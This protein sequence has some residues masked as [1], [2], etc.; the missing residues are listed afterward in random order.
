MS[1]TSIIIPTHNR[2]DLLT[3]AV[4][5]AFAAGTKIE[6]IV[7]DDASTDT[8]ADVCASLQGIKY[9]RLEH[10]EGVAGA[11]NRGLLA[12]SGEYVTFL[13]DDDV[14][15]PNSI[16]DQVKL[17]EADKQAGLIF[18]QAILGDQSGAPTNEVYP[19]E[20]AQGDVFWRLMSHN[21]IPCGSVVFRRS[22]VDR[23][24]LLD[25]SIP[26]VDDWDLWV[27][28]AEVYK[29]IAIEK[30]VMIWR[31]STSISGQGTSQA[32]Y[33][34]SR[35][36]RQFRRSWLKLSRAAKA[37]PEMK[38]DTWRQFSIPMAAHVLYDSPPALRSG[39]LKRAAKNILAL[40]HLCPFIVVQFARKRSRLR[41]LETSVKEV[42]GTSTSYS[43]SSGTDHRTTLVN[44]DSA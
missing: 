23:V 1:L 27:R 35:A 8:T 21:F 9:V 18:G 15:L 6:V 14:R 41:L 39:D 30:P 12:S 2:P 3:R 32:A 26:G 44:S 22:C 10:N 24:G 16:D 19:F 43:G 11:R 38:R 42:H 33:M 7:V 37:S 31:R 36:A 17:L 20:C 40:T 5:S 25:T 29:V 13:D 4:E 28:I 34:V